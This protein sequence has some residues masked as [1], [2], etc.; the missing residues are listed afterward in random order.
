M[1]R[2][3]PRLEGKNKE[4]IYLFKYL[5]KQSG[6]TLLELED[7]FTPHPNK[8]FD[9]YGGGRWSR[10]LTGKNVPEIGVVCEIYQYVC[11]QLINGSWKENGN[12]SQW[13]QLLPAVIEP[14]YSFL[15]EKRSTLLKILEQLEEPIVT[16]RMLQ[17]ISSGYYIPSVDEI[18]KIFW[19]NT[20][21]NVGEYGD[22]YHLITAT[23]EAER[24]DMDAFMTDILGNFGIPEE[25][26]AGLEEFAGK[27]G[28]V[29]ND[30]I[31][32]AEQMHQQ[33]QLDA[34]A[35]SQIKYRV[36]HLYPNELKW[37][38]DLDDEVKKITN[39]KF[40]EMQE[41]L[42]I[43][44]IRFKDYLESVNSVGKTSRIY[45]LFT[46]MSHNHFL[47]NGCK[48]RFGFS[49]PSVEIL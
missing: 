42:A 46:Q 45:G 23:D 12:E 4:V 32:W 9:N 39:K 49:F 14:K 35:L 13:A 43:A 6:M 47:T 31:S 48:Q 3:S 15:L 33:M 29:G 10:W 18:R 40:F 19:S 22:G 28:L 5:K 20:D 38:N 8:P 16:K 41:E 2:R 37:T 34:Q 24:A 25:S 11:N 44:S 21:E 7:R 1:G 17:A 26:Q 30:P 36:E 27:V